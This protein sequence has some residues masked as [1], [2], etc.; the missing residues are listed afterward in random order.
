MQ[1]LVRSVA[2]NLFFGFLFFFFQSDI[3][4]LHML[5]FAYLPFASLT[6]M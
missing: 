5:L 4:V 2:L 3:G 1:S 6:K